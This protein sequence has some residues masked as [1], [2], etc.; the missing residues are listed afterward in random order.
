VTRLR[1]HLSLP[2]LL[3]ALL[4]S[5]CGTDDGL[6]APDDSGSIGLRQDTT[7]ALDATTQD[8]FPRPLDIFTELLQPPPACLEELPQKPAQAFFSKNCAEPALCPCSPA[9][10][11]EVIGKT[12]ESATAGVDLC[13]MELQD[14]S[15]SGALVKAAGIGAKVRTILDDDYADPTE[16]AVADLLEAGIPVLNDSDGRIMH[17]KFV[18][19]DGEI[20]IVSSANFSSFDSLSNAN[21]LVVLRSAALAEIFTTRF[22][23]L[24]HEKS[25]HE[26]KSPGPFGASFSGVQAEVLFGPHWAPVERLVKAIEEAEEAIHF[27]IFAFTLDEVKEALLARCGEIELLGVYDGG[28]ASNNDSVAGKGWCAS[29]HVKEAKVQPS[30]GV[31]ADYGFRKLHHKLLIVD[32]GTSNGLVLTGSTNWSYSAAT[33][34]DEV[35][36]TLRAPD[37]VAA[38]E[39]EFQARFEEAQ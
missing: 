9:D 17:S 31:T 30:P 10:L 26:V 20:V 18:V 14:F 39:S 21:N 8:L 34:N 23:Q 15:V 28:Q 25:F 4:A 38:F 32:P 2:L 37:V 19:I 11:G 1:I 33:K 12:I 5:S 36:I 7:A 24:W 16:Y 35:M 27:S 22:D 3:L 13:V 6:M 29:A